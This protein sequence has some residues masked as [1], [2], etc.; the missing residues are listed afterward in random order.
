MHWRAASG[1]IAGQ[2]IAALSDA[3]SSAL[4]GS[5]DTPGG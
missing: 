1:L 3:S 4:T 2:P 5:S